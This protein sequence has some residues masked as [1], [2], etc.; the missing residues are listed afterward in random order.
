ME[1]QDSVL[2]LIYTIDRHYQFSL[3]APKL[4]GNATSTKIP[5]NPFLQLYFCSIY[6]FHWI[7]RNVVKMIF[8]QHFFSFRFKK[9]CDDV[10]SALRNHKKWFEFLIKLSRRYSYVFDSSD[11]GLKQGTV[12]SLLFL[13]EAIIRVDQLLQK[14]SGICW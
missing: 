9:V 3:N 6:F 4:L 10:S 5:F 13:G 11:I 8:S 12:L 2:Q 7:K 14:L 1:M